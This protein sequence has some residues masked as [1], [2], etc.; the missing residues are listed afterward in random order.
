MNNATREA[1]RVRSSSPSVANE[2]LLGAF[3]D[4]RWLLLPGVVTAFLFQHAVK[5][6]C[7][8][9]PVFR[10]FGIRTRREIDLEKYALKALRGDFEE[11]TAPPEP[12]AR[13]QRALQGARSA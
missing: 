1:D 5:G 12:V 9:V 13:A 7:P 11:V 8:P 6:W 4:R 3:V 2:R 10:R